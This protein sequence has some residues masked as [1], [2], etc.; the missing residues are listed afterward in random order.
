MPSNCVRLQ[1]LGIEGPQQC[2]GHLPILQTSTGVHCWVV[3]DGVLRRLPAGDQRNFCWNH[4]G[5][6]H[7]AESS[8]STASKYYPGQL[9]KV[10]IQLM[11]F[12]V[13]VPLP[14]CLVPGLS[15]PLSPPSR[16]RS[17]PHLLLDEV[18]KEKHHFLPF[19]GFAAGA[20]ARIVAYQPAL[21]DA[22]RTSWCHD[23]HDDHDAFVLMPFFWKFVGMHS[24]MWEQVDPQHGHV[25]TLVIL[26]IEYLLFCQFK[27]DWCHL[28]RNLR[29]R[30]RST[31]AG[32]NNHKTMQG[33]STH[34]TYLAY[35]EGIIP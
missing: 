1:V 27:V 17:W 13:K 16:Q 19:W 8:T 25:A 35:I 30:K 28:G 24:D 22:A 15:L 29:P 14:L 2:Q 34:P 31:M 32:S 7:S 23:D 3:G 12:L 20:D 5:N 18:G 33:P 26:Y 4:L 6:A 11:N 9:A 10:R 21:Q